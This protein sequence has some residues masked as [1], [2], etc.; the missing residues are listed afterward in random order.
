MNSVLDSLL[1]LMIL[2]N[3]LLLG[4]SRLGS[5]IRI[6]A[7]QGLAVGLLPV[8]MG[9]RP[10]ALRV[11]AFGAAVMVLKGFV[12]PRLLF[13]ALRES[14]TS[15]EVQPYVGFAASL[16]A[17]VLALAAA[18]WLDGRLAMGPREGAGL[19]VAVAFATMMTGLFLIVTRKTAVNQVLGYL[20]L[21]NGTYTFGL[22]I[23]RDIP[24]LVEMGVLLDLFAA[25]L[26]M[27]IAIY[28]INREFDHIESARLDTL[29]G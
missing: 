17:G 15:R 29:K 18:F 21:E 2:T 26:V 7:L 10:L 22:A 1:V 4:S 14:Q 16:V 12:F 24:L 11:V 13:R 3:L 20:V 6:G 27:G 9:G 8:A 28:R 23:A 19:G 25:V 5:C